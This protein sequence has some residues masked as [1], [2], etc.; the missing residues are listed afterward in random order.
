MDFLKL[1]S[2]VF[3]KKQ[4]RD[5]RRL[6][7]I[8]DKV[9]AFWPSVIVLSDEQ[10]RAKTDEFR[11]RIAAGETLDDILPEAFAVFREAT[12]RVLGEGRIVKDPNGQDIRF[13]AHFDVQ[14]LGAIALHQGC[15]SEMK[16]GEGKTQVGPMSAYLNALSG[17]GVHVITVNDYLAKRD[18]EWMGRI[19]SFLGLTVGCLDKTEPGSIERRDAYRCDITYGTNNEF[20]FDYLRD[21]MATDAG[22]LVQR[23]LNYAIID[24]VDNILIDEA[25]TPLIISGP[26]AKSNQEYVE[27][28]PRVEK[29]VQ[30]Q[31]QLVG[32]IADS[33]DKL[34]DDP[35]QEFEVGRKLLT[36]KRGAPKSKKFVK[37]IKETRP[38]KLMKYVETEL[39]RDRR[40]QEID[41]ELYFVIDESGHSADL[42]DMGREVIG[43]DNPDFFVVPDLA[44]Q[45]GAIDKMEDITPEER[46]AKRDEAHRNYAEVNERIHSIS[47]LLR[48]FSMFE[49]DVDY[50]V[51]EG[52]ILIV[53]E[54]T[55]RILQGRRY[56]E[57]LHQALEAKE[58]VTVAGENQTLATITFQNFFKMYNK[59]SGMTGTAT[60]EATEFHDI[61]KLDVVQVPTNR[62]AI[63]I[64]SD[65]EVY[66]TLKEKYSA[67]IKEVRE[68]HEAGRPVL[69][70][71]TSIEKSE[72]LARF[73]QREGIPHEVLNAKQHEREATIVAQAGRLGA[74]MIAT[75][76]AGRGTDILLGGNF[77]YM[78]KQKLVMED[79]DPADFTSD[80]LRAKYPQL[81]AQF[82]EEARK[83][84]EAGGLHVI[85][86]ERH[87]SRR[88]DNQ[89]R[90]RA[91]RQGDPGSSKFFL[92]LD[93]D[94]MRMFGGDRIAGIMDR[95]GA[96]EGEAI[97]HPWVS[98]A[99][100]N[101]Q[102]RVEDRNFEIRKHLKEYDDVMNLQRTEIYGLRR[103]ALSGESCRDEILD[104]VA[105]F[106]EDAINKFCS[107]GRAPELWNLS[108]LYDEMAAVLGTAYRI[109]EDQMHSFTREALFDAIW[110]EAKQRYS[111]KE[112]RYGEEMMRQFERHLFLMVVDNRWKDHLYE[113][114]H[115]KSGVQYR[116]FG[117][118]NPLYE[119]QNEG[120][121][122]F[123]ELR[124]AVSR[125]I[126]GFLFRLEAVAVEQPRPAPESHMS[127]SHGSA[128]AMSPDGMV[129]APPP[130]RRAPV[131]M[132][133]M[134]GLPRGA[135]P[136]P[137][138]KDVGRNDP[139]PCGSG[140]KFKKCH[141]V[142]S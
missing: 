67:V 36:L 42:T 19:C 3:G 108:G 13:Y 1:I 106:V 52:E 43:N 68:K 8:L 137:T 85:G 134:E 39:L 122:A 131:P 83:V 7:P 128:S 132:G 112:T 124:I 119:Y 115:L 45:I 78:A 70:G 59:I 50:V 56:S 135:A 66:K 12:H 15:I 87:E 127:V 107:D 57:G 23:E 63:R 84:R 60:T 53:D 79:L 121:K 91:G 126:S 89:L 80:Q 130:A 93:D 25:R 54:F 61:Y 5:M 133:G 35:K 113:M 88:I 129:T 110:E 116:S 38:A 140:K 101:S 82:V 10:L 73:L 49:R 96:E 99:I 138:V 40:L 139:C 44:E 123:E 27:L 29:L 51:Q 64:D 11:G 71:T 41:E 32:R 21:N 109:P 105:G 74:V 33:L 120:A 103:R 86:T 75:N 18:S 117:Q 104:Q 118:K 14:V 114:D 9:T 47:Q 125:E 102:K 77:E 26:A 81:H 100:S 95:L 55:G 142:N 69:L 97:I 37:L 20:G 24:E 16:T 94:L 76:M 111:D 28:R 90:G 34:L 4:D 22:S 92:S 141:G 65:D 46:S 72:L 2:A 48:A 30:M 58:K 6:R 62:P 136:L 17:K 31:S 98:R